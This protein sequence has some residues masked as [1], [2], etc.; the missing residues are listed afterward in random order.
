M[1]EGLEIQLAEALSGQNF[2]VP[3]SPTY[4]IPFDDWN[5]ARALVTKYPPQI[6]LWIIREVSCGEFLNNTGVEDQP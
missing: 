3:P 6:V 2:L 5:H 4:N 1:E